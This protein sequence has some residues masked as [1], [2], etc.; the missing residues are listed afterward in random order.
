MSA[1]EDLSCPVCYD[2]FKDPVV[3]SCCHSI[4]KECLEEFW[5]K[6]ERQEC[7]V[8]KVLSLCEP[9]CNSALKIL[10]ETYLEEY[11]QRYAEGSER[12][13]SLHSQQLKLFCL[14][15]KQPICQICQISQEHYDHECYPI[16]EA[17]DHYRKEL[18]TALKPLQEM[19]DC[20]SQV[21]QS[22]HKATAHIRRQ[23]MHTEQQ[24]RN[25]FQKLYQ[26]LRFEE[27]ERLLALRQ[28]EE[29]KIQ[30][31]EEKLEEINSDMSSLL[32][33]IRAIEEDIAQCSLQDPLMVSGALIDEAK[34]LGNLAYR[35]WVKIKDLVRYSP[36]IL[37]PNT[38]HKSLTLSED[39][40]SVT[41]EETHDNPERFKSSV[42]VLGSEGFDSG[43]H[44]WDI[45][46][47]NRSLWE[48]GITTE[49]NPKNAQLFYSGVWSVESNCGFYTR[50]PA[51]PKSPFSAEGGLERIRVK[52]DWER[53]QVSFSDPLND[54][55]IKTF[56]HTFTEKVYPFFWSH[57]K[58]SPLKI[59]PMSILP[60]TVLETE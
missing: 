51:R 52:L 54:T 17:A 8:C 18:N 38:A 5:I 6:K 56:N 23:V 24:I 59:L 53:G 37:D 1:E 40:T 28:E 29:R 9:E 60:M 14:E 25:E 32:K 35:M 42:C 47:A 20:F 13:C 11:R 33:L 57:C 2:I 30:M 22:Y 44:C 48:V 46:V 4:C 43:S 41:F 50:S 31:M 36:I 55:E 45:E 39:L 27:A 19:L 58:R 34:H 49:S 10:C 3:L 21:K 15:D 26:F 12:D 7:P 16:D